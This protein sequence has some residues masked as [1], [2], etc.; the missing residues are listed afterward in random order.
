VPFGVIIPKGVDNLLIP[1]PVS[2]SHIGFSTLRME[3]C[4]MA[5]GQAAGI[6]ASICIDER[7]KIKYVH[8]DKLQAKLIKQK[9]TLYFLRDMTIDSPDFEMVQYMGLLGYLPGWEAK[10][11]A[12]VDAETATLW[13]VLSKTKVDTGIPR[14]A[15]LQRIYKEIRK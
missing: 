8:I 12:T 10:L 11:D 5:M 13:S 2:G 7:I 6:A 9:A 3:P 1:V 14:K 15:T 4:W